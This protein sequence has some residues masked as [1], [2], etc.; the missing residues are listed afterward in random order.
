MRTTYFLFVFVLT[1][2]ALMADHV[3]MT[4]GD[5]L[6]GEIIKSDG[7]ELVMKSEFAGEVKIQWDSVVE[8]SSSQPLNL[9]LSD[10]RKLVGTV[11]AKEDKVQ[12]VTRETGAVDVER[13][14]IQAIRNEAEE[15]AYQAE[16]ERLRN[17]GVFD[18]WSTQF[19]VGYAMARG[20][21]ETSTFTLGFNGTRETAS[22]TWSVYANS[23]RA[24]SDTAGVS[25]RTANATRGGVKYDR[26]LGKKT[27][28]FGFSDLEYDEFQALDL[29]LVAGGGLSYWVIKE[30]N[31][32]FDVSAGGS[33]NKEYFQ[34][35]VRRSSG[36]ILFGESLKHKLFGVTSLEQK[37]MVFPN[38]S[39]TGEY[40]LNFDAGLVTAIN[41]WL[42]W[43]LTFSDRYLSNPLPGKQ[44]NDI[45][46]TTGLRITFAQ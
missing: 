39:E 21:A 33:F 22:D 26:N 38:L 28:L 15:A 18:L 34:G 7:K 10:A 32:Q 6:T 23:I 31:T 14:S 13:A 8:F 43:Q 3:V 16:V 25:Q 46:F 17:P 20:N 1:T 2:P 12:V 40:R 9:T 44:S 41:K 11:E 24:S 5:R 35:D 37:L 30:E 45:L 27:S 4:N 36:E 29:R 42:S 19:D